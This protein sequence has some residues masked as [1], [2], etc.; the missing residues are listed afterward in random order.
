VGVAAGVESRLYGTVPDDLLVETIAAAWLHDT[1]EDTAITFDSLIEAKV[2]P[3][4]IVMVDNLTLRKGEETYYDYIIRVAEAQTMARWI[5]AEDLIHN[6]SSLSKG[7]M[8]DKY[9][10]AYARVTG[11]NPPF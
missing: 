9:R 2:P 8:L 6:G 4:V 5:K 7:S 11:E 3:Q 1:V 10:F